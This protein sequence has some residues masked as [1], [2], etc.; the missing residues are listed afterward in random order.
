MWVKATDNEAA[1]GPKVTG[2]WVLALSRLTKE[3][4]TQIKTAHTLT[5]AR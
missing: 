2:P 5:A 1:K 3:M 4:G